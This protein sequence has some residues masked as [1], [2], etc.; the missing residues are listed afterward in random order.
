MK[1]AE[2][3]T[4]TLMPVKYV[5]QAWPITS[6]AKELTLQ[7]THIFAELMD[8]IGDRVGE[9]L[10]TE[11]TVDANGKHL[12]LFKEEDFDELGVTYLNLD[13]SFLTSR[14]D[15]YKNIQ[16]VVEKL[17]EQ[18]IRFN[19]VSDENIL[20]HNMNVFADVI[21]EK[22]KYGRRTGILRL[23]ISK[24]QARYFFDFARWSK[25]IK[26]IVGSC[27][28]V[29]T[30][31]LYMLLSANQEY[32]WVVPYKKL[33]EI[34]GCSSYDTASGTWKEK[35]TP[36]KNFKFKVLDIAKDEMQKDEYK[37]IIDFTF[38][39]EPIY[40]QG[41]KPSLSNDPD[42]IK[43][44]VTKTERGMIESNSKLTPDE[45]ALMKRIV[46]TFSLTTNDVY[47]IMN[48]VHELDIVEQM[49]VRVG[50]IH[51]SMEKQGDR[52]KQKKAYAKKSLYQA[53]AEF[54]N[55]TPA[56]GVVTTDTPAVTTTHIIMNDEMAALRKEYKDDERM[57][58]VL[59]AISIEME[60]DAK[61]IKVPSQAFVDTFAKEIS[62][63]TD[64]VGGELKLRG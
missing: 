55:E 9:L 40:A 10:T 58:M 43:F 41:V 31:R 32:D 62:V 3:T 27:K 47:P 19:E 22:D 60:N 61:Y 38:D 45:E 35:Y 57:S 29:H 34:L 20:E 49:S 11:P 44:I 23:A 37:G 54:D 42:K 4:A 56:G 48:R 7:E 12:Y 30:A 36:F 28:S 46:E 15:C 16:K 33:R 13:L 63:L 8:Q 18:N 50:E 14:T 17:K 51:E 1:K 25:Y 59:S 2:P 39:Y 53:V 24:Y 5:K 6:I 21:V 64:R 26:E 52:I